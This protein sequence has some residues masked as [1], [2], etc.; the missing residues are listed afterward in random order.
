MLAETSNFFAKIHN[1]KSF[2]K[3]KNVNI[4]KD[5]SFREFIGVVKDIRVI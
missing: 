1:N 5:A 4:P 2:S 3:K